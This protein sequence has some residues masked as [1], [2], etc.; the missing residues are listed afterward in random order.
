[1]GAKS[2]AVSDAGSG[3]KSG[4]GAGAGS[5]AQGKLLE[6][7][8]QLAAHPDLLVQQPCSAG[9][10]AIVMPRPEELQQLRRVASAA[11]PPVCNH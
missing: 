11:T 6:L 1:M 2:G 7:N 3:A 8:E 5:R 9:F 4:D 10:L